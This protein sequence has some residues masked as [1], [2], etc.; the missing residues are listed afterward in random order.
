MKK[1]W[2]ML[3]IGCTVGAFSACSDDDNETTPGGGDKNP[4]S[5]FSVQSPAE[6][7]GTLQITGTG[8]DASTAKIYLKSAAGVETAVENPQFS[9]SGVECTVPS[10]LAAGTYT[11]LVVQNGTW[12][13]GK[14][15][16]EEAKNPILSLVLPAS[17]KL[18]KPLEIAGNGFTGQMK[19]FLENADG[20]GARVEMK[21]SLSSSGVTCT[22]PDG[23]AAG[24]YNVL[25]QS[26][27]NEWVLGSNLPAA[28]Y[29][30][31]KGLTVS[32]KQVPHL[33]QLSAEELSALKETFR[34]M[35]EE[36]GMPSDEAAVE[37]A[38]QMYLYMDTPLAMISF[39]YD[40][41][42][43]IAKVVNDA[44]EMDWYA[45]SIDGDKYTAQ[46]LL[47][48]EG[49]PGATSFEWYLNNGRV[50]QSTGNF[51]KTDT[52]NPDQVVPTSSQHTWNYDANGRCTEIVFQSSG[53][54]YWSFSFDKGNY[55]AD[56]LFDYTGSDQR[57]NLFG[58]DV[59]RV[60]EAAMSDFDDLLMLASLLNLTGTPSDL[61]PQ[62]TLIGA[63]D[64]NPMNLVYA[65][66]GD[67]YV[68]SA[69]WGSEGMDMMLQMVPARSDTVIDFI[70][71]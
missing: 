36:E 51:M 15:I 55:T 53:S 37:E 65:Q 25:L 10:T 44:Y 43:R 1:L 8:F 2:L 49:E 50:Q 31:L 32:M 27:S 14:V 56:G 48:E 3:L 42:G 24:L 64:E 4:I 54:P 11:V 68:T 5:N 47:Y 17:I 22:I 12:E 28:V 70:Y 23:T 20:S 66:D 61:L 46:N 13:L 63:M 41:E 58:A 35:L 52:D 30:Q 29:K 26:G 9:A 67:G 57:N 33:D 69:S 62:S 38:M 59:A 60:I 19:L 45:F 16:L 21:S 6:I 40:A 18:N 7:G 39:A 34:Q 71:E